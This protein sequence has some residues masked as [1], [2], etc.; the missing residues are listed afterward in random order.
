MTESEIRRVAEEMP[1]HQSSRGSEFRGI[2][3]EQRIPMARYVV[4][5][6]SQ[7][8]SK[9]A[10]WSDT[11]FRQQMSKKKARYFHEAGNL[12]VNFEEASN[13]WRR[14]VLGTPSPHEYRSR[15]IL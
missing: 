3:I 1:D 6:R 15:G 9:D 11:S 7:A 14:M 2:S 8:S 5:A 13:I 10:D 12:G 4:I